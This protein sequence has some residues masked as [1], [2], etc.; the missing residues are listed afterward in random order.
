MGRDSE[1]QQNFHLLYL[2]LALALNQILASPDSNSLF[3][4]QLICPFQ[5]L[6]MNQ[7]HPLTPASLI[8]HSVCQFHF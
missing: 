6:P 8:N 4:D 1:G 3:D 2:L 5:I 7:G